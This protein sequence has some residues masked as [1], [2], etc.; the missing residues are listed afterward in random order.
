MILR[1]FQLNIGQ[2][3]GII[4]RDYNDIKDKFDLSKYSIVYEDKEF[5]H[6]NPLTNEPY[7]E[8]IYELLDHVF[9]KF[10]IGK[11]PETYR[12]HSLSVSDIIEINGVMYYINGIG[13]KKL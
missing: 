7:E 3:H 1:I 9:M 4:Y 5:Q 10:N 6:I 2:A 8:S 12:G 11:K 13:F